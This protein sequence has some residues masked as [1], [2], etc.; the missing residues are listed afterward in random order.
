[1]KEI[2]QSQSRHLS[3]S[4]SKKF[5]NFIHFVENT[6]ITSREA[7]DYASLLNITYKSLNEI[8]KLAS[9]KTAKQLIDLETIL[10]AKRKLA[11]EEI[12]V[13]TL[14]YELGFDE[15]TNFVKYFKRHTTL[16]PSQFKQSIK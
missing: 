12:Q 2:P 3:N 4:R 7:S 5:Q 9:N 13:Q 6:A 1:M 16:T 8:C 10:K 14:A 11:V 15:V